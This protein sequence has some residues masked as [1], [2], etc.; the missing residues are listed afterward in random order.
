MLFLFLADIGQQHTWEIYGVLREINKE[1][2][3]QEAKRKGVEVKLRK[4]YSSS[5]ANVSGI[6][7]IPSGQAAR[8]AY[9]SISSPNFKLR[10]IQNHK[11]LSSKE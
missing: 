7:I 3:V 10:Y 11:S 9:E 1:E 4:D 6:A 5:L 2:R 8:Q